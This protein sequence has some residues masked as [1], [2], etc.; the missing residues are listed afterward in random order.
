MTSLQASVVL[1]TYNNPRALEMVLTGLARQ[2]AGGFEVW[3]ADDGSGEATREVVERF[4]ARAPWPLH[5]AWHEDRGF[6]KSRILNRA[7][8]S[9]AGEYVVH[10]DG[11]CIPHPDYVGTHL[12]FRGKGRFLFGHRVFLGDRISAGLTAE[13]IRAGVLEGGVRNLLRGFRGEAGRAYNAIRLPDPLVSVVGAALGGRPVMRGMNFSAWRADLLAINGWNEEY[14]G[15]GAEDDDLV[16]RLGFLGRTGR[17]VR[18]GAIL[19]HLY[20]PVASRELAPR[21][22]AI[23]Q[24][25]RRSQTPRCRLGIR[26]DENA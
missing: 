22:A 16:A 14:E 25:V 15:W 17:S 26:N 13:G 4:A 2:T 21:N 7:L 20:H 11:D 18:F 5:H 23:L 3:I 1:T 8:A 24:A 9:M 10:L 12:R 19:F 6:R